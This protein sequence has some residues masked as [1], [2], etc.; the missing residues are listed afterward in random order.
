MGNDEAKKKALPLLFQV[1][2][3]NS[4]DTF[5]IGPGM[6]EVEADVLSKLY[7]LSPEKWEGST[8][9]D[10][11][12]SRQDSK[13]WEVYQIIVGGLVSEDKYLQIRLL[14]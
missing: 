11:F 2:E 4:A 8:P 9:R 14:M 7:N 10:N 1:A 3:I 6:R 5:G 12:E 13:A